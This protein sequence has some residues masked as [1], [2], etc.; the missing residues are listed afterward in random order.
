L[1]EAA[2]ERAEWETVAWGVMC[3]ADSSG[4][5]IFLEKRDINE[6]K[7]TVREE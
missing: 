5:L 4:P 1:S 3:A 7:H 2:L 6:A